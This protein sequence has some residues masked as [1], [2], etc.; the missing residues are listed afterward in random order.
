MSEFTTLHKNIRN[1]KN[2]LSLLFSILALGKLR[3]CHIHNQDKIT[4][5]EYILFERN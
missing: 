1:P 5:K 3:A 2:C 4:R